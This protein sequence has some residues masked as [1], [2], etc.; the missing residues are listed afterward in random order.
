MTA[1]PRATPITLANRVGGPGMAL[2][3]LE[4]DESRDIARYGKQ[5][6]ELGDQPSIAILHQV[7]QEEQEH[8]RELGEPD[9]QSLSGIRHRRG[10][11]R[12]QVGDR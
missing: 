9:P 10:E 5:L 6:E 7:I 8:Y 12:S 11:G 1:K 4:I 2:R 3:R